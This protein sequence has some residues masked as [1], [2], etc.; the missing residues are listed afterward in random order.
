MTATSELARGSG[1]RCS[2]GAPATIAVHIREQ[3]NPDHTR[4][5]QDPRRNRFL[6]LGLRCPQKA[7]GCIP[8]RSD[9]EVTHT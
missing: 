2:Q 4:V 7:T 5:G 9:T 1:A 3:A 8:A 6:M